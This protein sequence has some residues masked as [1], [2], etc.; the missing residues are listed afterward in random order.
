MPLLSVGLPQIRLKLLAS[1]PSIDM[2][3]F[4]ELSTIKSS[5]S[6]LAVTEPA[7]AVWT[8]SVPSV[9]AIPTPN[10][11]AKDVPVAVIAPEA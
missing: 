1:E 6:A 11:A 5:A 8:W 10:L 2:P 9:R 7:E 4:D 3:V